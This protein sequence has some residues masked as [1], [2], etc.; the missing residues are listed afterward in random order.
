MSSNDAPI[1]LVGAEYSCMC[2]IKP[3][4]GL[5]ARTLQD[6][7]GGGYSSYPGDTET[8]RELFQLVRYRHNKKPN[9]LPPRCTS[10]PAMES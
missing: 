8:Q 5:M 9:L 2:H 3:R 1:I 7:E 10:S 6:E 4:E